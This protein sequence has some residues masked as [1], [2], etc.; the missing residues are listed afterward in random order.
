MSNGFRLSFRIFECSLSHAAAIMRPRIAF[1][2]AAALVAGCSRSQGPASGTV[3]SAPRAYPMVVIGE[4]EKPAITNKPPTYLFQSASGIQ[5]DLNRFLAS[6]NVSALPP[7]MLQLV[8]QPNIYKLSRPQT[9]NF[10]VLDQTTLETVRGQPFPGFRPGDHAMLGIGHTMP[11][12]NDSDS[13]S[14]Y[15]VATFQVQ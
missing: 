1:Y 3:S 10:Y 15:W 12:R 6:S 7:D 4:P 5:L 9:T 8:L 11:E 13:F 2:L 14:V